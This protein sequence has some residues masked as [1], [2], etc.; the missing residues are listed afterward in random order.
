M[1]QVNTT[2]HIFMLKETHE[3]VTWWW[4]CCY[5]PRLNVTRWRGPDPA[6]PGVPA[7]PPSRPV[8]PAD[9]VSLWCPRFDNMTCQQEAAVSC[10]RAGSK[11]STA[12]FIYT[13]GNLSGGCEKKPEELPAQKLSQS[14][15]MNISSSDVGAYYCAVASCDDKPAVNK[16]PP[17][18]EGKC[19]WW[20]VLIR[21]YWLNFITV[22]SMS[23]QWEIITIHAWRRSSSSWVLL[24]S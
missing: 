1:L 3:P 14:F 12:S 5:F 24:W 15:F 13:G 18:P 8:P 9:D 21:V 22:C 20:I 11:T 6:V 7:V 17:E 19:K 10:I 23:F 4:C 2:T 16:S